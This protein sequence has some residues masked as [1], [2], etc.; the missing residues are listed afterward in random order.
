MAQRF[1]PAVLERGEG[2][3]FGVW[4]PDFPG[5]IAA[6]QSQEEAMAKA[7]GALSV[8]AEDLAFQGQP[9]PEPTPFDAVE[10]P[11]G[12][13]LVALIAVGVEP[14]DQSERV[15]VY[16]PKSLL[17]NVDRRSS[18]LGMSRSSFFGFAVS[19][20]MGM[21]EFSAAAVLKARRR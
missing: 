21:N 5:V 4:F 7:E 17:K 6:A 15:N 3:V 14:P 16:L 11:A 12:C 8:G 1:Y 18:E 2:G 20:A 9:M 13:E 19:L 10:V